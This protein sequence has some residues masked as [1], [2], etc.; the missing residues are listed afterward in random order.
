M[1]A[2]DLH[3]KQ[4]RNS[5]WFP[6]G[7]KTLAVQRL[8]RVREGL[9]DAG[10]SVARALAQTPPRATRWHGLTLGA[11]VRPRMLR[12][13]SA[14]AA[15]LP[16]RRARA[17]SAVVDPEKIVKDIE[18]TLEVFK[19]MRDNPPPPPAYTTAMIAEDAKTG[20]CLACEP[21]A[22]PRLAAQARLRRQACLRGRRQ[23]YL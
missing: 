16:L 5:P 18:N 21:F 12:I 3:S 13:A 8:R 15:A 4:Q 14:R 11:R 17:L 19:S 22:I 2:H 9:P 23:A 20:G 6:P 10:A 1:V 7:K